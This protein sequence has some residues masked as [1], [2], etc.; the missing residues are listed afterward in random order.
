MWNL[1]IEL[2]DQ[3]VKGG[4]QLFL[5]FLLLRFLIMVLNLLVDLSFDFVY[6]INL[7]LKHL[8]FVFNLQLLLNELVCLQ[9]LLLFV[10]AYF[11]QSIL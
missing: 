5:A 4:L 2:I 7:F 11:F 6:G 10:L 3:L 9:I 8:K 1:F